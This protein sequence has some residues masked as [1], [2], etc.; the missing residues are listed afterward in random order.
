MTTFGRNL[1]GVGN[2]R[3]WRN[4]PSPALSAKKLLH[5]GK[6]IGVQQV[7]SGIVEFTPAA[8][9]IRHSP[10]PNTP[11]L[12]VRPQNQLFQPRLLLWWQRALAA[13]WK[14]LGPIVAD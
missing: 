14:L 3:Q 1:N 6:I 11:A 13:P 8:R 5:P 2:Q 4:P 9:V 7:D 12:R 10:K